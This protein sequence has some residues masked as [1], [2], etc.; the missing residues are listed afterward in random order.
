[1][2]LSRNLKL[3]L[4]LRVQVTGFAAAEAIILAVLAQADVVPALTQDAEAYALA[5]ALL[6]IA[7]R[8]DVSHTLR[9]AR[10]LRTLK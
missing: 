9:V 4:H 7:L 5:A 2:L 3:A 8:A 1:M 6:F 10:S